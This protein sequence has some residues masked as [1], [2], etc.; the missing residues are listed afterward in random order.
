MTISL[1]FIIPV[2][3]GESTI[4]RC[5]TSIQELNYPKNQIEIIVVDNNSTDQTVNI[6]KQ[7]S[8]TIISESKQGRSHARNRGANAAQGEFLAFVDCDCV[9]DKNWAN[10]LL[11]SFEFNFIGAAQG[12]I[13][14]SGVSANSLDQFRYRR[15]KNNTQNTFVVLDVIASNFP[16]LNSAAFIIRKKVFNEIGGFDFHMIR[17]EDAD[18]ARRIFDQGY[19]LASQI[20]AEAYVYWHGGTWSSYIARAW[21]MGKSLSLYQLKWNDS[22]IKSLFQFWIYYLKRFFDIQFFSKYVF[23]DFFVTM[24]L[25]NLHLFSFHYFLLKGEKTTHSRTH[26]T[27]SISFNIGLKKYQSNPEYSLALLTQK[28][29]LFN[30]HNISMIILE[31]LQMQHMYSLL[32]NQDI[33]TDS[34]QHFISQLKEVGFLKDGHDE[35]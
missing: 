13:I 4:K 31:G 25:E 26:F 1:S 20:K 7:F 2:F 23:T 29:V 30:V 33:K 18:I 21:D 16:A 11:K 15:V 24:L 14:P 32:G 28:I 10:E 35:K 12:A 5:L 6:A 22:K 3:N 17:H 19:G 9:L 34:F 8:V 27:K